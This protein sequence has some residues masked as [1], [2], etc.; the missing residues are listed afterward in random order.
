MRP[1]IRPLGFLVALTPLGLT[2]ASAAGLEPAHAANGVYAALQ[3]DGLTVAGSHVAFPPPLL[4]DGAGPDAE[5][6]ALRTLAGSE[7]AVQ[8]FLRAS[9]TAPVI[10][11]VR[12]QKGTDGTMIRL[13]DVWFAVHASLDE[14]DPSRLGGR[15]ADGET[16][17]AG[18]M[19]FSSHLLDAEEL[20]PRGIE[21]TDPQREWF[22][23]TTADLLDRIHAEATDHALATRS[24]GSWVFAS[25]TDHRFDGD[26]RFPNLWTA[27]D[28]KRSPKGTATPQPQPSPYAGGA[29][30]TR[31][32][33]L[34]T[35]PGMLLVEGH[36][37]FSEPHAWFDGAP[38]LRSKISLVAQDQVRRLRRELN[39]R[40]VPPQ[41]GRD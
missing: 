40:P 19:K 17:E 15:R 7:T 8:E 18:N 36:L 9:V 10:L 30:T 39:K 24:D 29:S 2:A 28:R 31:I 16:V 11:K 21:R 35:A 37:V 12:D 26:S 3:R 33:R 27:L 34:A 32:S 13:A 14:I 22:S 41:D 38:I 20:K 23:H 5:R 6:A 4:P 1:G 25:Q